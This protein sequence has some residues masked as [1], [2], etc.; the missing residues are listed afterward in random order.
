M[1][2]AEN[3]Y[4]IVKSIHN[5]CTENGNDEY[6]DTIIANGKDV[7]ALSLSQDEFNSSL[8]VTIMD[9]L[10]EQLELEHAMAEILLQLVQQPVEPTPTDPEPTEPDPITPEV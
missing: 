4:R 7:D 8:L 3:L 2:S 9:I 10:K 6:I 1:L 5:Y